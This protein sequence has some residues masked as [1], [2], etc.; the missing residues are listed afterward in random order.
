M[1]WHYWMVWR[2]AWSCSW[3]TPLKRE[4]RDGHG[5]WMCIFG[6]LFVLVEADRKT[7]LREKLIATGK[8]LISDGFQLSILTALTVWIF[9]DVAMSL[10]EV[11]PSYTVDSS[12]LLHGLLLL[13]LWMR[14]GAMT[15][16][17]IDRLLKRWL[18]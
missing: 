11:R 9:A 3:G 5:V 4:L 18:D 1:S 12:M 16:N 15:G 10:G 13:F 17:L 7:T 14:F 8:F 2:F 6:K